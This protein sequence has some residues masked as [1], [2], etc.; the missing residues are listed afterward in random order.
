MH[1]RYLPKVNAF[2]YGVYY[3]HFPLSKIDDLPIAKNKFACLSFYEKD[4]GYKDGRPLKDWAED[5]LTI[6]N[7]KFEGE[8]TL[9]CLPRV[10]GYVFN[11]VS[12]Y[13]CHNLDGELKHVICEVNNTFGETHTYICTKDDDS[14]ISETDILKTK[15]MFHVS[16]F[17]ERDGY[18]KFRFSEK[19]NSLGIWID[20]YNDNDE[21]V[22]VTSLIGKLEEMNSKS[23]AKAFWRYPLVTLKTIFLIHWQAIKLVAKKIKYV[24]KPNQL[25]KKISKTNK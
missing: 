3:L 1:K 24:P 13:F 22:L 10:L 6:N 9:V 8:V 21:I 7:I 15:K 23:L 11:P 5:I 4:H 17:L 25:E 2:N 16:P 12:F 18:Y 14:N 19:G 20:Y